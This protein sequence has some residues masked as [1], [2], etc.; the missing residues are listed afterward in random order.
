[1]NITISASG[2]TGGCC[3]KIPAN[4]GFADRK[5]QGGDERTEPYL[6]PGDRCVRQ[7]LVD[8]GKEQCEQAQIDERIESREQ[9]RSERCLASEICTKRRKRCARRQRNDEQKTEG[10]D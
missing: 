7:D 2:V 3:A 8:R 5:L 10:G 1:V 9:Q 6:A 4:E